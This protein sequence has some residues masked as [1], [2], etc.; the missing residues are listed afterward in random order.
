[1]RETT[2]LPVIASMAFGENG[3]TTFGNSVEECGRT[4]T[5]MGASVLGANCMVSI[6]HYPRI[7]KA[8]SSVSQLPIMAQP[9]AGQP[10]SQDGKIVYQET[11]ETMADKLPELVQAGANIIGGCCG[12][13][14][15]TIQ[16]FREVLERFGKTT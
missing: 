3:R 1:V 8:Y 11:P 12:T 9:N 15:E 4:M 13:T 2:D 6:E 16:M 7:V 5:E 10:E 14:P